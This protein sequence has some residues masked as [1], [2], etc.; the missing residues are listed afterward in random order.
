MTSLETTPLEMVMTVLERGGY[1]RLPKP[2][3]IAGTEFDFEAVARGT[4]RSHDLVLVASDRVPAVQLQRLLAGLARSLDFAQSRR[5]ITLVIIGELVAA[6]KGELERHARVLHIDTP[7]PS[8]TQVKEA[9]SVLLPLDLPTAAIM[10][11]RDPLNEVMAALGAVSV[12]AEHLTLVRAAIGGADEVR[13]TL[14]D[15]VNAGVT[16]TSQNGAQDG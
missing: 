2:L 11:G 16:P 4:Q 14:R 15:Y 12:T 8:E 10:H 7:T 3:T 6:D 13:E 9:I 1:R 5:P